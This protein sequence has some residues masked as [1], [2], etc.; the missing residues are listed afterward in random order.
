MT[1]TTSILS[2][3]QAVFERTSLESFIRIRRNDNRKGGRHPG[4]HRYISIDTPIIEV[5]IERKNIIIEAARRYESNT[6]FRDILD[7]RRRRSVDDT[8]SSIY[9]TGGQS[10]LISE[11]EKNDSEDELHCC[12]MMKEFPIVDPVMWGYRNTPVCTAHE[13]FT[14]DDHIQMGFTLQGNLTGQIDDEEAS[15]G[16]LRDHLGKILF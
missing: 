7:E 1:T 15:L 8:C 12:P 9:L 10:I 5:S 16:S 4:S 3:H 14:E 6:P 13:A 2:P 11:L